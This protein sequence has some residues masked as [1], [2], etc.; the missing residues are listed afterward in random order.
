MTEGI[1]NH[2][3]RLTF[4][5]KIMQELL[6]QSVTC[7]KTAKSVHDRLEKIYVDAMDFDALNDYGEKLKEEIASL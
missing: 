3:R 5:R 2:K 7:L 6:L 1:E 4:N